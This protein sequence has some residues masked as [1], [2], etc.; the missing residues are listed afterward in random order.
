MLNKRILTTRS[1]DTMIEAGIIT[2]ELGLISVPFSCARDCG[3]KWRKP[4][5]AYLM[6]WK[7]HEL[8]IIQEDIIGGEDVLTADIEAI[9]L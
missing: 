1:K 3:P 4:S 9:N 5:P 2:R 6:A 7:G 8:L